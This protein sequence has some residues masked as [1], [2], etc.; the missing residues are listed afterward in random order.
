MKNLST[1]I[2]AIS[3]AFSFNSCKKE[4]PQPIPVDS[5]SSRQLIL[6]DIATNVISA[7]YKD[8]SEKGIALKSNID[9]LVFSASDENLNACRTDWKALKSAWSQTEAFAY[10]PVITDEIS[11][12]INTWPLNKTGVDSILASSVVF[13][14]SYLDGLPGNLK[15][16]QAIEYILF[17]ADGNKLASALTQRELLFLNALVFKNQI[18]I[19]ALATNWKT[20]SSVGYFKPFVY[21]GDGSGIYSS[22]II[23]YELIADTLINVLNRIV[24]NETTVPFNLTNQTLE[25]IPYSTNTIKTFRDNIQGIK[26]IYIGSYLI[27]GKGLEEFVNIYNTTLNAKIKQQLDEALAALSAITDPFGVAITTQAP[28]IQTA[29]TKINALKI[30]LK[31]EMLPL[32]KSKIN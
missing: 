29:I 14:D 9:A 6:S 16:L 11:A 24:G 31:D 17:G 23:V 18:L 7:T 21:A 2:L 30:S 27:D 1:F 19:N 32:F 13:S 28:Q 5:F 20:D 26:N 10:G 22:Q 12:K 4:D 3:A 25:A 15:G 8:V